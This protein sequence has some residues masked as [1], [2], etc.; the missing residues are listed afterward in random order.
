MKRSLIIIIIIALTFFSLLGFSIVQNDLIQH[1]LPSMIKK[2]V[3]SHGIKK[4]LKLT[5]EQSAK[6]KAIRAE[7]INK[8]KPI[9]A[10]LRSE[11]LKYNEML[12]QHASR[13][14]IRKQKEVI[15]NLMQQ[16]KEIHRQNLANFEKILTPKQQANFQAIKIRNT[17]KVKFYK[18]QTPVSNQTTPPVN[19][20]QQIKPLTNE[21]VNTE[22]V[23]EI[24][25][26][27]SN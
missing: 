19:D 7:S 17:I 14:E 4:D 9:I 13:Q 5:V 26:N 10:Q 1:K 12:Q 23:K 24:I 21:Q 15:A 16:A 22:Q 18:K 8:I 25:P 20:N 3:I 11:K 6:A 2:S 27:K